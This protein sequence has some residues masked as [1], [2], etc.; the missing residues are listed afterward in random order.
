MKKKILLIGLTL[1][2]TLHT[3]CIGAALIFLGSGGAFLFA[4]P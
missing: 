4:A 2:L 3:S 1:T